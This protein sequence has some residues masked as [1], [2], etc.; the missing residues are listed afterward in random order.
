MVEY[1]LARPASVETAGVSRA[2]GARLSLE[3]SA[4]G[5]PPEIR[6]VLN[7]G[8]EDLP[9][10]HVIPEGPLLSGGE[11]FASL[12]GP[13]PAADL[14]CAGGPAPEAAFA[15]GI[16]LFD[17]LADSSFSDSSLAGSSLSDG[18]LPADGLLAGLFDSMFES[19]AFDALIAA[20]ADAG[21]GEAGPE[22]SALPEELFASL[23][24]SPD[25]SAADSLDGLLDALAGNAD[26]GPADGLTG[27]PAVSTGSEPDGPGNAADMAGGTDAET[28]AFAW[29]DAGSPEADLAA[30][31]APAVCE[32][33]DDLLQAMFLAEC[34]G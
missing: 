13:D 10:A 31:A 15:D 11:L 30:D 16:A 7:A 2:P 9:P 28:D 27:D 5:A 33:D 29:F 24:G 18:S 23:F 8:S 3:F 22:D 34:A 12:S 26:S 14:P 25:G 32:P 4:D 1:S 20:A 6:G 17:G 21:P 19:D